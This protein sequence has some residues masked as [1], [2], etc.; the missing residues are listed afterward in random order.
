MEKQRDAAVHK[1]DMAGLTPK[2]ERGAA[3]GD[4]TGLL[5]DQMKNPVSY[6]H[7]A[8]LYGMPG[9]RVAARGHRGDSVGTAELCGV[10]LSDGH[11]PNIRASD[12]HEE[13]CIR[14]SRHTPRGT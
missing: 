2:I 3:F 13:M 11:V 5:A 8:G 7:L 14:D 4:L 9:I 1:L 10:A 12:G 6:T